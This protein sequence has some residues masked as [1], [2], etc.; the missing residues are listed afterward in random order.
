MAVGIS[1]NQIARLQ[2]ENEQLRKEIIALKNIIST[3]LGD[4]RNSLKS[5]EYQADAV[6]QR[7]TQQIQQI[8]QNQST[9]A[10]SIQAQPTRTNGNCGNCSNGGNGDNNGDSQDS[11]VS[12]VNQVNQGSQSNQS[13]G[14]SREPVPIPKSVSVSKKGYVAYNLTSYWNSN[15]GSADHKKV[16]IGRTVAYVDKGSLNWREDPRMYSNKNY[17]N[18]RDV[19]LKDDTSLNR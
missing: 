11:E 5:L 12:Q 17:F 8:Q 6:A 14:E 10:K 7:L 4:A 2:A 19:I 16:L 3:F 1:N 9:K 15:T 18:L 13:R